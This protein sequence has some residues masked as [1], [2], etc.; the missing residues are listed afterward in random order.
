MFGKIEAKNVAY[1]C[2]KAYY[3]FKSRSDIK[4]EGS[5]ESDGEMAITGA[6]NWLYP[7]R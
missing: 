5:T 6:S 3:K 1:G 4:T 7:I 2:D